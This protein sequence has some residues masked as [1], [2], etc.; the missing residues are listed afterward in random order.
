MR[1]LTLAE[2]LRDVGAVVRFVSRDHPGNLNG[3][4]RDKGFQCFELPPAKEIN[5]NPYDTRSEYASWLGVSQQQD[6]KETIEALRGIRPD[7][8]IVDHYGLDEEWEKLMRPHVNKIMVIDDLADRRHDCDLLLDQNY[9]INGEKRYDDLVP[10]SCTK[11]LG[12]KYALLRKEFRKARKNLSLRSGEVKRVLVFFGGTD[13]DN[14][15]RL[16]IEALSNPDLLHLQVD[17]VIG[18]Q[19]PNRVAVEK[20]IQDRPGTSLHI[21][22]SNMAQLMSKADLAIGAGGS[23]TWER[24]YLGLPSIVIPIAK[25]QIPSAKDLCHVGAI[26]SLRG[27]EIILANCIK[28][29]VSLLLSK[30]NELCEMSKKGIKI[31]SCDRAKD[32]ADLIVDN[33]NENKLTHRE[34]ILADAKLYW[35]WANDPEVRRSAFNSEPISWEKHQEWFVAR[36]NDS[37]CILLIFESQYGP[38]GQVRLDGDENKRRISYSVSRQYRGK[39]IGKKLISE[40]I[41]SRPS[42][43]K[44]FL[45]EVKKE[46]LVSAIIFE[47]LGFQRTE[48]LENAYSFTLDL[49]DT[50][51]AA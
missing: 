36:L 38:V 33:L 48:L 9:F 3:L 24:L 42:F 22:A 44:S 10:H 21:Q 28:E 43:A 25:N 6:G 13:P 11:L 35:Q 31:V 4:I 18:A 19:N 16:A 20:V 47:K 39:G 41:S 45:A 17:V 14:I 1:C 50:Y 27:D 2:E 34:A 15:T 40:V 46:N 37:R 7:W 29:Q 5:E 32:L 23:A 51:Q 30:P 26:I 12:P 49:G 8:L